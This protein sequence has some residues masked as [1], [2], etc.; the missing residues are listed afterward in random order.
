M[1][2]WFFCVVLITML[3]VAATDV[4]EAN[5]QE[6]PRHI[7]YDAMDPCK[8]PGGPHRGCVQNNTGHPKQ[9]NK[10]TRGCS[11]ITRCRG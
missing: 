2:S 11:K 7:S 5:G 6:P 3:V 4:A 1:K 10:Y 9:H 8:W